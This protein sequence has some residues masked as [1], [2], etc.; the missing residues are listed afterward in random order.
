[1]YLQ[2]AVGRWSK[3]AYF[4]LFVGL[5]LSTLYKEGQRLKKGKLV[6]QSLTVLIQYIRLRGT[7]TFL[8]MNFFLKKSFYFILAECIQKETPQNSMKIR[9]NKEERIFSKIN[10]I[11]KHVGIRRNQDHLVDIFKHFYNKSGLRKLFCGH[12]TQQT[13]NLAL[14]EQVPLDLSCGSIKIATK[15]TNMTR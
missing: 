10:F 12:I 1:M 15:T 14:R 5:K 13:I 6:S 7:S 9:W 2:E 4:C 8:L 3:K 11:N